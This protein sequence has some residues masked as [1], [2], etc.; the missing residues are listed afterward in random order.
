MLPLAKIGQAKTS[1]KFPRVLSFLLRSA[2]GEQKK[3]SA[4]VVTAGT[5]PERNAAA[6]PQTEARRSMWHF[7]N[8]ALVTS[9]RFAKWNGHG[10]EGDRHDGQPV[11]RSKPRV[12]HGGDD[13]N[14]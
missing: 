13:D 10:R 6:E 7:A 14:L 11:K 3:W 1:I 4:D 8:R 12:G 5:K 2:V 9:A